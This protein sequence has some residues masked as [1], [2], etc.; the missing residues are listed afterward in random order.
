MGAVRG[1]CG[2][3]CA[4]RK[5]RARPVFSYVDRSDAGLISET[6]KEGGK[7]PAPYSD[8]RTNSFLKFYNN[9]IGASLGRIPSDCVMY[10]V[11]ASAT[12]PK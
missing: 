7:V 10:S 5:P 6:K 3:Q 11:H 4:P 1:I 12:V 2:A 9:I 8:L